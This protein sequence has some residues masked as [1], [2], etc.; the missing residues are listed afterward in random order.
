MTLGNR[1]VDRQ[2]I[3]AATQGLISRSSYSP[4]IERITA[5][6]DEKMTSG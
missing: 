4:N 6:T 1:L 2:P 5:I 3:F